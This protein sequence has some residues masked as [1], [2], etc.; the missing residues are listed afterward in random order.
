M[1]GTLGLVYFHFSQFIR[2]FTSLLNTNQ[3]EVAIRTHIRRLTS[4]GTIFLPLKQIIRTAQLDN[5]L[6]KRHTPYI[7]VKYVKAQSQIRGKQDSNQSGDIIQTF[8]FDNGLCLLNNADQIFFHELS[9]KQALQFTTLQSTLFGNYGFQMTCTAVITFYNLFHKPIL[10]VIQITILIAICMAELVGQILQHFKKLQTIWQKVMLAMR[11]IISLRNIINAVATSIPK[12]SSTQS[13]RKPHKS[14]DCR[15][16]N[17]N[18]KQKSW[19]IFRIY[20][21]NANCIIY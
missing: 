21:Y 14:S 18:D 5:I 17:N 7:I 1:K 2:I 15:T 20:L 13:H 10:T 4:I 8:I 9:M 3:Q 6:L 11:L 16:N 12:T 19:A